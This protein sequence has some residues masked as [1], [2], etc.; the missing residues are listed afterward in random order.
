MTVLSDKDLRE[1]IREEDAVRV[2]EGSEIDFDLQLGP[3]SMDLR[4]GYEFGVLETRRVKAIDTR[5]MDQY[6]D[7]KNSKTV[8]PEEGMVV[9]P[10][11]FVLGSTLEKLDVPSNLVARIE[12]R[13]SYARL[14]LIP[15]AAAGFVD[16]GFEGQITLEI[17]NLGNVPITIY[18]EDRICQVVF[19]T[20]TSKAENP[21]GEK[22]DS[23]YMKQEGATGSRL[24]EEHR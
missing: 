20:M 4:L 9:H 13:S 15:H 22:K 14:G 23:K 21:Y 7:I 2:D 5:K 24:N 6:T 19:E 1:I 3:S 11:E 16:P 17:Q 12:G 8:S 10:G 18:P